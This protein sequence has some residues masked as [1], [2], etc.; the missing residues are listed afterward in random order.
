[1]NILN[2][3][4]S[5]Q[6]DFVFG[7]KEGFSCPVSYSNNCELTVEAIAGEETTVKEFF[8]LISGT[9]EKITL[10]FSKVGTEL[11][12]DIVDDE[13]NV[14]ATSAKSSGF[15]LGR[16]ASDVPIEK[17]RK[18]KIVVRNDLGKNTT[19][20]KINIETVISIKN[21]SFIVL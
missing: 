20:T 17:N 10:T 3:V 18:Y 9:L 4:M 19:V 15:Q 6:T 2:A 8:P 21:S 1:M 13:N 11:V 14:V 7:E 16:F 5:K 12:F